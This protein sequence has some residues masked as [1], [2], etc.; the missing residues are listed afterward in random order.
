MDVLILI[1]M[2]LITSIS[3]AV[4]NDE[5][6]NPSPYIHCMTLMDA[7]EYESAL[8]ALMRLHA[9][10]RDNANLSYQ[11]GIC[12]LRGS[13]DLYQAAFFL[14]RASKRVSHQYTPLNPNEQRA[15]VQAFFHLATAYMEA[16]QCE[17][18]AH[19]LQAYLKKCEEPEAKGISSRVRGIIERQLEHCSAK[20]LLASTAQSKAE[21]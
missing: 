1:F 4:A 9:E 18:A 3:M 20:T 6:E 2:L 5:V 17:Q 8:P 19:S 16:G 14:E 15:P 7:G 21:H 13:K 12:L 10:D 11:I